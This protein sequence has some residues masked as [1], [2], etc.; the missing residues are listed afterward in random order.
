[1]SVVRS[2]RSESEMEFLNTA[3]KLQIYTIQKCVNTI[4][5]R[6]TF[7]LANHIADSA[8]A[9]Y[10]SVKKANSVYPLNQHEVQIRRDYFI[11][12]YVELQSMVSQ[13]EVAQELLHFET[14][15]L[16]EWSQLISDEMKLIQAV[17]RKDRDRYKNLP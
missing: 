7:F 16:H 15:I 4:P 1:M 17:M 8:S 9:V 2:K 13:V 3:R 6:Y 12:A 10:T 11:K 5:K 14:K